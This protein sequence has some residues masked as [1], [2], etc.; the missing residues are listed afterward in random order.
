MTEEDFYKFI[1]DGKPPV[2][3]ITRLG[4]DLRIAVRTA[5]DLVRLDHFYALKMVGKHGLTPS[6][7]PMLQNAIDLG[8]ATMDDRGH[9]CFYYLDDVIFGTWFKAVVKPC[10]A[11]D[12]L[13]VSTFH[14]ISSQEVRRKC[15]KATIL[16]PEKW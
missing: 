14:P 2:A 13:W 10:R 11:L 1:A 8:R 5:T 7:L 15:R 3:S 16:R 4:A 6:H 9:L 12:E